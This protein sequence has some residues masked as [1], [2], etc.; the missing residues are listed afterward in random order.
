M[1]IRA[2]VIPAAG[3]SSRMGRW[4]PL[5]PWGGSTIIETVAANAIAA[6]LEAVVVAG[7]R[8][9]ELHRLFEGRA[10]VRVVDNPR[11][12][13]G[14]LGSTLRGALATDGEAFFVTPADMPRIGPTL[15]RS[16][17]AAFEKS[18]ARGLGRGEDRG[19]DR[20]EIRR[21]ILFAACGGSLGHPVLIPRALVG[22]MGALDRGGR[23]R[24]FLLSQEWA[25][26]ETGDPSVLADLDTPEEY[27]RAVE[28]KS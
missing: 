7:H 26:L 27:R 3:A 15:Y 20:G 11:W 14:M 18:G 16:L 5:L 1:S 13:E 23:M 4:K 9:E 2:C 21:T 19:E 17:M 24:E 8:G 12:E 22:A 28:E 25:A 6:G 10:G